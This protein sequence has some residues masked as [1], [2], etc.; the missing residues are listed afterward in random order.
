M[1]AI[2]GMTASERTALAQE[3]AAAA[4]GIGQPHSCACNGDAANA[5]GTSGWKD[6]AGSIDCSLESRQASR[7]ELLDFIGVARS[8]KF[9]SVCVPPRWTALC[10]RQLRDQPTKVT[11]FL[12]HPGGA[13]LTPAK[14]AEAEC[15]LR[16]GADE[17]WMVADTG[18][19]RSGDLDAAYIDIRAVAEIAMR[20]GAQL[21]VVLD[22]PLL[23]RQQKVAACA[24]AKLAGAAGAVSASGQDGSVCDVADV[25][26][27]RD[28]IGGE[29]DVIAAGGITSV[30]AAQAMLHAGATRVL[31]VHGGPG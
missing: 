25:S 17:L 2:D 23:D 24:V 19:I 20:R 29:L 8:Q 22:L 27:M 18:G 1:V 15:L 31:A 6:L 5:N 26:L 9:R 10:V 30:G 11:S 3:I 7:S 16:L 21:N 4:L 28:A 13:S 12:G 14:C